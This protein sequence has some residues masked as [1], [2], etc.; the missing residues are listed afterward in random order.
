VRCRALGRGA[1]F[2]MITGH[3]LALSPHVK[4][5]AL[6]PMPGKQRIDESIEGANGIGLGNR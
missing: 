2:E 1:Y 3:V 5:S 6:A 4:H